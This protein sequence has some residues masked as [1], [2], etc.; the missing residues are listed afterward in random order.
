LEDL[1]AQAVQAALGL[2]EV[3]AVWVVLEAWAE[4][5]GQVVPPPPS[6]RLAVASRS[7]LLSGRPVAVSGPQAHNARVAPLAT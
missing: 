6:G 2:Q 3:L 4:Q 5:A 7:E 1:D